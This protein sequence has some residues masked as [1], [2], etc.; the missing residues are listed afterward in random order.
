MSKFME[1]EMEIC[2]DAG[3]HCA[4]DDHSFHVE[5]DGWYYLYKLDI[6]HADIILIVDAVIDGERHYYG[7]G[8]R[9]V[10][11]IARFLTDAT[12]AIIEESKK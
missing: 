12:I 6:Y 8:F 7:A 3:F 11:N 9:D 10:E 1:K 2:R 4:D 5:K